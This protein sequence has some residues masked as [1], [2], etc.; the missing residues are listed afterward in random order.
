[1]AAAETLKNPPG[2]DL[3]PPQRVLKSIE[4]RGKKRLEHTLTPLAVII[5]AAAALLVCFF[6]ARSGVYPA[7]SDTMFY[8]YRGDF[9]YNSIKFHGNF[10]PL[11]DPQWYNGVQ[12]LRYW[13]PLCAWILAACQALAGGNAYKGYLVFVGLIYFFCA[14]PWMYIG[15]RHSRPVLGVVIGAI[16][17][18]VPNNLFML[19]AEGALAR[20]VSMTVMPVFIASVYDYLNDGCRKR[21]ITI[22]F[23]FA[24]IIMCHVGWAGM[25]FISSAIFFLFYYILNRRSLHGM[26]RIL[27]IAISCAISLTICGIWVVPSLIGG[28]T[29]IDSSS[30]ME[31]FFQPLLKTVSPISISSSG[32]TNRWSDPAVNLS[33]YFGLSAFLL[34]VFGALLSK[35]QCAPGFMTAI[36]I[37]LLTST[38]AY[39][40]LSLLPGSQY[41]WM[42]RFISIALTFLFVSL[43]FWKTLKKRIQCLFV[44]LLAAEACLGAGIMIGPGTWITPAQRYGEIS[45]RE[46]IAEGKQTAVQ[47]FSRIEAYVSDPDVNYAI[48]GYGYSESAVPTS[49]GQ[50]IQAAAIYKNIININEAA[51]RGNLLYV[52]D[53]ALELGN[54]TLLFPLNS[55]FRSIGAVEPADVDGAADRL[56]YSIAAGDDARRLYR[57]DDSLLNGVGDNFGLI[58]EYRCIGI[59]RSASTISIAFPAVEETVSLCIND[60]SFEELSQYDTVFL[61]GFTYTDRAASE[62]MLIKLSESGTKIVIMADGI[63]AD[64]STG[65]RSFLGLECLPVRFQNSFP[66]LNTI[67]GRLS[68]GPFSAECS[69]WV[70]VYVNGLDDVWGTVDDSEHSLPFFGTVKNGNIIVIGLNLS[71]HYFLTKDQTA[72]SLLSHACGIDGDELPG[73]RIVPLRIDYYNDRIEIFSDCDNVCTTLAWQDIFEPGNGAYAKNNLTY[74]N[75]GKTVIKLHYPYFWQGL[76]VTALGLAASVVFMMAVKRRPEKSRG[77]RLY[78]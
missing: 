38:A 77:K 74:V 36:S 68:C 30:I 12:T 44:C 56:G 35:R 65:I 7:G 53:R 20:S 54:D 25:V 11:I 21:L 1:M 16:W 49:Y 66:E 10:Y 70:T 64:E 48:S 4:A 76:A 59:G 62:D 42:L 32:I 39:P 8:I 52:F 78:L 15:F 67:Y 17:F 22:I 19:Y 14:V 6:T 33:P 13:S 46:F 72:G 24:F 51:E 75:S 43:L 71:Y 23:S 55:F 57:L 61:S 63:P 40:V 69:D 41:L 73:R 37:C 3:C 58:T 50:G 31:S 18:F 29:G 47:R 5:Y 28:I 2:I 45:E 60:Y 34:G 27:N 26:H 9:I